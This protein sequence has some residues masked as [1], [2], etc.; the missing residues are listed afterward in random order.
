MVGK[1][2]IL[3]MLKERTIECDEEGLKKVSREALDLGVTPKEAIR[4][5]Q[6]GLKEVGDRF[7]K[8]DLF[9]PDLIIAGNVAQPVI[10]ILLERIPEG[11]QTTAGTV[12]LGTVYGDIHDLGKNIVAAFLRAHGYKVHDLGTDVQV[13]DF[14]KKAQEVNADII[15]VSTLLTSSMIYQRDIL[16]ELKDQGMSDKFVIIGGSAANPEWAKEIN[17]HAYARTAEDAVKACD[18]LMKKGA[19]L[20]RPLIIE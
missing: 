8:G 15:A 5:I 3:E 2:K 13:K 11:E 12:V 14:V 1:E 16:Q 9:L 7:S 17:V 6:E 18:L 4:Q 10:G 19:K 20:E